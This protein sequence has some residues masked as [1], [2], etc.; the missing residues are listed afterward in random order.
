MA[1][2]R[3]EAVSGGMAAWM[4]S[5]PILSVRGSSAAAAVEIGATHPEPDAGD[6]MVV[7]MGRLKLTAMETKVFVLDLDQ[8]AFGGPE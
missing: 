6:S 5:T 7:M 8:E 4:G 1:E 3:I 2:K